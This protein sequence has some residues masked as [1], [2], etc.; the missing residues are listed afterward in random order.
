MVEFSKF[1]PDNIPLVLGRIPDLLTLRV[2]S[3]G[4]ELQALVDSLIEA[5][6][7]QLPAIEYWS[8]EL[9]ETVFAPQRTI[10][11]LVLALGVQSAL[12]L[13]NTTY[14]LFHSLLEGF[15]ERGRLRREIINRMH[16]AVNFTTWKRAALDLDRLNGDDT[17]RTVDESSFYDHK[18]LR[19]R[20]ADIN[21][22]IR[23]GD[24]HGLMFRFRGGLARDQYGM[25]HE[26]LF[27]RAA[28]GTKELVEEYHE[29]VSQALEFIADSPSSDDVKLIY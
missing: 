16:N 27:S 21:T 28:A 14:R 4:I 10:K 6:L 18:L 2:P 20:I 17:W 26:G 23:K 5:F 19:K 12:F 13:G 7:R 8:I 29:T 15:T 11:M 25:Q 24:T 22:M 9:L 3:N 1:F